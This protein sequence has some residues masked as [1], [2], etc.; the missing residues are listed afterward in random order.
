MGKNDFLTPKAV[1]SAAAACSTCCL[2]MGLQ[3][4]C[5]LVP[6]IGFNLVMEHMASCMAEVNVGQSSR[7]LAEATQNR[8][9]AVL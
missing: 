2:C 8:A 6:H 5:S 7:C 3:P 4:T 9:T 1:S